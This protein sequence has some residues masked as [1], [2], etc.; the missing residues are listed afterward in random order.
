[1]EAARVLAGFKLSE[2]D[3]LRSAMGKKDRVKMAQQRQKFV[4]GAVAKGIA[5]DLAEHL[6]DR[7]RNARQIGQEQH[8]SE[9]RRSEADDRGEDEPSPGSLSLSRNCWRR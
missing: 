7:A 4:K 1:M 6:F 9:A 3:I 8:G 2:A 5:T